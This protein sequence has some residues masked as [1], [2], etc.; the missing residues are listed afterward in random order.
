MAEVAEKV[1]AHDPS[2]MTPSDTSIRPPRTV[3]LAPRARKGPWARQRP[4]E[5]PPLAR[6]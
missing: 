5:Q 3:M 4:K 1:G 6:L 2:A